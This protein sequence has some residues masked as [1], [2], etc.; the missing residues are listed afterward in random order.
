ME[1]RV[2]SAPSI[3]APP[4]ALRRVLVGSG[5]ARGVYFVAKSFRSTS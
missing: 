1:G 5:L 2:A 3:L 4:K